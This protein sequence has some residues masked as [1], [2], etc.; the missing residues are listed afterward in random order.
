[1]RIVAEIPRRECKITI[2]SWNQKYLLKFEQGLLEQT[3][4]VRETDVSG[5]AD[6]RK[7]ANDEAFIAEVLARFEQMGET[8]GGAFARNGLLT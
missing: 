8:L 7:L 5:D 1:M 6:V 4:K 2:F 3:Y